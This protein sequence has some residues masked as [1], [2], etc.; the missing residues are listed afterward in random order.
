MTRLKTIAC[1]SLTIIVTFRFE[2]CIGNVNSSNFV[3]RVKNLQLLI[4]LL[5]DKRRDVYTSFH[6]LILCYT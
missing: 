5:A 2:L 3:S 6:Y 1:G 4:E